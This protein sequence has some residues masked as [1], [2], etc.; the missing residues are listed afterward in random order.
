MLDEH[1]VRLVV[2][3]RRHPSSRWVPWANG[4]R[5]ATLLAQHG[6]ESL[7]APDLGGRR[8]V[9]PGSPNGAIRD[10]QLQ[11]Y[12]DWMASPEFQA[13]VAALLRKAART[14]VAVMCSEA[15]PEDCHRSLLA[16]VLT[17]HGAEVVQAIKPGESRPHMLSPKAKVKGKSVTYPA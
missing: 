15:K 7:H 10:P 2:D 3:V 16:D 9:Q 6:I 17:A 4:G 12:A 13:A 1:Q 14:R 11:G 5:L 8:E